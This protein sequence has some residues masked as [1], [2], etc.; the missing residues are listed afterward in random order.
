MEAHLARMRS[1]AFAGVSS[2]SSSDVWWRSPAA[3]GDDAGGGG[4]LQRGWGELKQIR[5]LA[6]DRARG[7]WPMVTPGGLCRALRGPAVPLA[8]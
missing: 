5:T 6:H 2:S 1:R 8:R 3:V 4:A 7:R